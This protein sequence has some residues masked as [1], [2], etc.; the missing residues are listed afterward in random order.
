MSALRLSLAALVIMLLAG[1]AMAVGAFGTFAPGPDDNPYDKTGSV[2][3]GGVYKSV[4]TNPGTL[5]N[6]GESQIVEIGNVR[7]NPEQ[8]YT[9]GAPPA[10]APVNFGIGATTAGAP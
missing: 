7:V 4:G 10:P 8:E 2:P 5:T 3:D 1:P 9:L 6:N